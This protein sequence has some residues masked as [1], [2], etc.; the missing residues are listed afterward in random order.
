MRSRV[1]FNS[2][3]EVLEQRGEEIECEADVFVGLQYR[4]FHDNLEEN[5]KDLL[6]PFCGI[7]DTII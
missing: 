1:S 5:R 2:C 4:I 6:V 3:A 7:I